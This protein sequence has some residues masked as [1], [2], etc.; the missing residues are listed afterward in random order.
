MKDVLKAT[1]SHN[2]GNVRLSSSVTISQYRDM[3]SSK[4]RAGPADFIEQRLL[5]RYVLPVKQ[6]RHKNRLSYDC[7][8]MPFNRDV[9]VVLSGLGEH[10]R[11]YKGC[12]H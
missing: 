9:R 5:E 1:S 2:V 12:R 10:T 11:V 4:D 6:T 7:R 3:E 8:V